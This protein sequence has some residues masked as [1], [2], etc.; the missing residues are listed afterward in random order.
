MRFLILYDNS[1]LF[2]E[3]L[4]KAK[5][6]ARFKVELGEKVQ[7]DVEELRASTNRHEPPKDGRSKLI[8]ENSTELTEDF[9]SEHLGSEP[10]SVIIGLC[11]DMCPGMSLN[12]M[13]RAS[14]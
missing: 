2:R 7:S 12:F 1:I 10:S 13:T 11:K 9:S 4:A 3:M 8:L 5:R 14:L 6:L